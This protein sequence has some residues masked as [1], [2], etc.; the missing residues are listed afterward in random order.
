MRHIRRWA[1]PFVAVVMTAGC[2]ASSPGLQITTDSLPA[3]QVESFYAA[4]MGVI[5]GLA[6]YRWTLK[7]GSLPGGVSLDT[8]SGTIVG[9]PGEIGNFAVTLGVEDSSVPPMAASRSL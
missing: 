9:A 2:G 7:K 5:G 1:L 8:S 3:A 6:P 4:T